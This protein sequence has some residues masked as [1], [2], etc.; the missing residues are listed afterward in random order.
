[1]MDNHEYPCEMVSQMVFAEQRIVSMCAK[2]M[3]IPIYHFLDDPFQAD[4]SIF[5]H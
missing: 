5:T 2:K 4:N 1:M 3:N